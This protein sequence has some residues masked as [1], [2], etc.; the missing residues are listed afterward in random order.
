MYQIYT[1]GGATKINNHP[2]KKSNYFNGACAVV[3][4]CDNKVIDKFSE[5]VEDTTNNRM[6]LGG[7]IM[8]IEYCLENKIKNFEIYSDSEYCVK[9]FNIWMKGWARGTKKD[10]KNFDLWA[11][12]HDLKNQLDLNNFEYKLNWVKAHNGN[13]Y[14]EMADKMC[15]NLTGRNNGKNMKVGYPKKTIKNFTP[16]KSVKEAINNF[17]SMNF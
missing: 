5:F 14:N 17:F 2:S 16:P 12:L 9:G 15:S 4:T 13:K 7:I 11:I 1:D 8:A 10:L 6:E 3:I